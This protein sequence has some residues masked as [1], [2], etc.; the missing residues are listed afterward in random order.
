MGSAA[1][2]QFWQHMRV[3]PLRA[4]AGWR[5]DRLIDLDAAE[6]ADEDAVRIGGKDHAHRGIAM[7][8]HRRGR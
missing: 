1:F 8:E 2:Q 4:L 5:R 6:P 3:R 7:L